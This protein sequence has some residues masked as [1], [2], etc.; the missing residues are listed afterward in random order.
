MG[1]Y[2]G[3]ITVIQGA[4]PH[5]T[6]CPKSSLG[7]S[8]WPSRI[9]RSI[10]HTVHITTKDSACTRAG[11]LGMHLHTRRQ[12]CTVTRPHKYASTVFCVNVSMWEVYLEFFLGRLACI[13]KTGFQT[14]CLVW[15]C[16]LY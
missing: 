12:F 5:K 10:P 13:T 7:D 3:K 14:G 1:K 16:T 15:I 4:N 9:S 6:N 8:G 11:D 2:P